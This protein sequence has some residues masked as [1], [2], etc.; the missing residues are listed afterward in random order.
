MIR[1]LLITASVL[2]LTG[3]A[4]L[5]LIERETST[6]AGLAMPDGYDYASQ[7][8]ALSAPEQAWWQGFNSADLDALITEA[9]AANNTLAQGLANVD[10]SRAS[11]RTA[12]AAFLPQASGS[13]SSSSNTSAGLDDVD[14]SARLSASYQLDLF[15]ANAAGRNAALANLDAA[16]FA[17]RAL[18]L[19]VQS[20]V[21]AGWFNLLSAREQLAVARRNL[22]I[23]ERIFEIVQFRY[24]AGVISGFDVSSQSAQLANARARIPQLESQITSQETALG[25]L[26]GRVP[27]GYTAPQADIL[28]IALP[29]AEPGLPSDLLLRRPDLMQ[30]EASLR[31][32]NANIDAARAAFFPS[33]DLGAGLSSALTGGT[34]LIGS[35]SASL[36]QTIFSGGRL[37]AQLEGAQARREGQLAGYRQ[38][39]LSALRDV[40]VSL[41]AIDANEVREDQLLIARD[42]A[43][44]ALRAAEIQYQAGTGDLTSLLNAQQNYFD[45]ANSYVLGRLDRLTAAINLY[46]AVGGGY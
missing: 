34:D 8:A 30:S 40:D 44:D 2:T 45:A 26:L 10:A 9:L 27:Q 29:A 22:E 41:K 1:T 20:D 19:T 6:D 13:L 11:L 35:L 33:I 4:S 39:I 3:C 32:A 36:A 46:V 23:S 14:A 25:I 15:G 42:A 5:N 24:E 18:E 17:Q 43:E 12:N 31:A 21:A 38:S 16:I 37:D 28:S 7:V